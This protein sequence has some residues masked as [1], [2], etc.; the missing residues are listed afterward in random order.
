MVR[1]FWISSAAR[2]YC[3]GC[4]WQLYR[5]FC[6]SL[7]CRGWDLRCGFLAYGQGVH[8]ECLD[9]TVVAAVQNNAYTP[10]I[11]AREETPSVLPSTGLM[12]LVPAAGL[13]SGAVGAAMLR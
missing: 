5:R 2:Y 8:P 6:C 7:R 11:E 3:H 9:Y 4:Q 10:V 12:L 1:C 13:V